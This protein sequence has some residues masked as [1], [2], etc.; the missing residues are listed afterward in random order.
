MDAPKVRTET[1]IDRLLTM[2][3]RDFPCDF[4][5]KKGGDEV[6]VNINGN[7]KSVVLARD[8]KWSYEV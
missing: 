2:L 7:G 4:A 8:G 3:C 5:V 6:K 1:D